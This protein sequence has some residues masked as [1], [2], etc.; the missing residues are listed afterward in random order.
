MINYLEIVTMQKR[1]NGPKIGLIF[2]MHFVCVSV[3]K[4]TRSFHEM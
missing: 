3:L 4:M 2:F 1:H